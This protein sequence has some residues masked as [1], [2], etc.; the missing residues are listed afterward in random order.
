MS[1]SRPRDLPAI[2]ADVRRR[3]RLKLALRGATSALALIVL[4]LVAAA[5]GVQYGRYDPTVILSLRVLLVAAL[6][7]VGWVFVARPLRR[8][9]SDEQVALYLEEHE[10]EL[11]SALVS[12][13][14]ASRQAPADEGQ[15]SPA[16]VSRLIESAVEKCL[17]TGAPAQVEQRR[18]ERYTM[19]ATGVL[20]LGFVIFGAGP[21][22]LRHALSALLLTRDVEAAAPYSIAVT[23]GSARVPKGADQAVTA[24]LSGFDAEEATLLVRHDPLEPFERLPLARSGTGAFEGLLFNV[25]AP[26]EYRVEADGTAS[27]IFTLTVVDQPYV[28]QL[29]LEFHIK[30]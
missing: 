15:R 1:D 18:L 6:A 23:P 4:L 10:P 24:T 8:R 3:W 27:P 17:A 26:L 21:A 9:V 20:V 7:A 30:G 22:M 11:E 2:I 29:G 14:D 5:V 19:A 28:P 13:V 16:L 12:A 25:A